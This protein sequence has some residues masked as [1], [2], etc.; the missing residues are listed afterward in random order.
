M[1]TSMHSLIELSNQIISNHI[2]EIIGDHLFDILSDYTLRCKV[3]YF[4]ADSVSNNDTVLGHL[5]TKIKHHQ[6]QLKQIRLR[7]AGYVLNL[8]CET[9]LYGVDK[10]CVTQTFLSVEHG[11]HQFTA[12]ITFEDILHTADEHTK[13]IAWHKKDPVGKLHNLILH[14]KA[15]NLRRLQFEAKQRE[16]SAD[17]SQIYRVVINGGIR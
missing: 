7:Y 9:I 10:D 8:V 6:P 16:A 5:A 13:L 3:T 2:G 1:G 15:N 11:N 12:V 4:A 17:M 14:I